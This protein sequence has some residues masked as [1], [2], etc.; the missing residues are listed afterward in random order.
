MLN[1]E[2]KRWIEGDIGEDLWKVGIRKSVG[3]GGF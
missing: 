3:T 1:E 2:R